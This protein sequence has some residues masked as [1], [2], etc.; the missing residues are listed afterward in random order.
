[1]EIIIKLTEEELNEKLA[2]AEAKGYQRALKEVAELEEDL[3]KC[4]IG[5]HDNCKMVKYGFGGGFSDDIPCKGNMFCITARQG[6]DLV[7]TV[8]EQTRYFEPY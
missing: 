4:P 7:N 2:E 8:L 6:H 3:E 5:C 1:M